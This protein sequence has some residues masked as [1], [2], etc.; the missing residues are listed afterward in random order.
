M[1]AATLVVNQAGNQQRGSPVTTRT[2]LRIRRINPDNP[3]SQHIG[4]ES[5]MTLL[6]AA[7]FSDT[8]HRR[9]ITHMAGSRGARFI[10][11]PLNPNPPKDTDGRRE[12]SGRGVRELQGK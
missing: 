2:F 1:E 4:L 10:T 7:G 8:C 9:T 5:A 6:L 3:L 11:F 12:E